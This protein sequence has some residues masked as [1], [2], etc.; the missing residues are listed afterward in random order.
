M[1]DR[2]TDRARTVMSLAWKEALRM[3]HDFIGTEHVLLGLIQ[4]SS[5]VA[6]TV[7]KNLG[8][9]FDQIRREIEKKVQKGASMVTMGQLPFTPRM[10]QVLALSMQEAD[11]L[12][13]SYIGTGHLLLGLMREN[14]GVAAET[15]RHVDLKLDETRTEILRV[16]DPDFT[17]PCNETRAPARGVPDRKYATWCAGWLL[18]L[19]LVGYL[20]YIAYCAMSGRRLP[21]IVHVIFW[22]V[23]LFILFFMRARALRARRT[24]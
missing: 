11:E 20:G 3:R 9:D 19:G 7:L 22:V 13:H 21:E 16:L 18:Q 14:E 10:K 5:G 12:G 23:F 17:P 2:F 4:E 6:T 8:V 24:T 1:F 15:L